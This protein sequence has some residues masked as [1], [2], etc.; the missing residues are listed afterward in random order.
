MFNY[1]VSKPI[2]QMKQQKLVI[3]FAHLK[4]TP[5]RYEL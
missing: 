3:F 5:A 1:R 2:N 4:Q